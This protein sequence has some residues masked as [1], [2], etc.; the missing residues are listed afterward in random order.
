L[1]PSAFPPHPFA[2]APQLLEPAQ[3]CPY[4]LSSLL[5]TKLDNSVG[6]FI[7]FQDD[8]HIVELDSSACFY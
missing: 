4:I 2:I 5:I 7:S 3:E 1:T 6:F 8:T